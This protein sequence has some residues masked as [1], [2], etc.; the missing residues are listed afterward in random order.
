MR[1]TAFGVPVRVRYTHTFGHG[2][3]PMHEFRYVDMPRNRI[4]KKCEPNY[5]AEES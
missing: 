2:K 5:R 1:S 4:K 3:I